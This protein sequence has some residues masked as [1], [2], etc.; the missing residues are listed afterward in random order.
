MTSMLL[1]GCFGGME[2]ND[3]A[4][5][6]LMGLDRRDGIYYVT[7]QIYKSESGTADPDLSKANSITVPGKGA[8]IKDALAEA[9]LSVGKRLFLGHIK[10]IIIGDGIKAPD[11]SIFVDSSVSPACPVAYSEDPAA[12]AGVLFEEGAFSAEQLLRLMDINAE[13]GKTIYTSIAAVVS[14][15]E[16]CSVPLPCINAEEDTV[17]FDGITFI[18]EETDVPPPA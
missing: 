2:V 9:E 1:T 17:V 7:L 11:L 3:R 6:Q 18:G 15:A 8:A 12:V 13:R 10:L 14:A 16:G 5:V 4:F